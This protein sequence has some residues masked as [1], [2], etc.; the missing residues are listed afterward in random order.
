MDEEVPSIEAFDALSLKDIPSG[1]TKVYFL[2]LMED[3]TLL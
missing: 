3:A 2:L 1:Y